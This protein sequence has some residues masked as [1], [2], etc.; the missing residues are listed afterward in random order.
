MPKQIR[1]IFFDLDGTLRIPT[2]SPTDAFL[3]LAHTFNGGISAAAE[4]RVKIWAH[5]Y[6]GEETLVQQDMQRFDTD[7]FWLNYSKLLLEQVQITHSLWENAK[8]VREYFG[9]A[10]APDVTLAPGCLETL[11]QLQ[12][13]GYFLGV[14]SN[15]SNPLDDTL[16]EL[17]LADLFAFSMAAGEVGHWKP[18][19]EIFHCALERLPHLTPQ[20]CMYIGDNYFADGDGA[21]AAALQPIIYDPE[22]LYDA[23]SVYPRIFRFD[24]LLT[25]LHT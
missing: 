12:A 15:R 18:N 16:A 13:R 24:E 4:K 3:Q 8:T 10:Y 20:E 11:Q 22:N 2:P 25:L 7:D 5:R 21:S 14:I 9:Q 23:F 19:P 1:A 6:W 17:G